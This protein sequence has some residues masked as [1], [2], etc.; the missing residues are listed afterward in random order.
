[1]RTALLIFGEVRGFPDLW[2]HIYDRIAAPNSADVFMHNYYYDE[3]FLDTHDSD[4]KNTIA[5]YYKNKGLNLFPNPELAKIFNPKAQILETRPNFAKEQ[6]ETVDKIIARL[7]HNKYLKN[8]RKFI[9]NDYS[10]IMGQHYS[11]ASTIKLKCAHEMENDFTYDAVI[12]TRLDINILDFFKVHRPPSSCL[13]KILFPNVSIFEQ[14]IMGRSSDINALGT[15]FDEAPLLYLKYCDRNR[16]FMSN[17]AFTYV[18]LRNSNIRVENFDYPLDYSD[19][20]NGLI[21][22]NKSFVFESDETETKT[23]SFNHNVVTTTKK[24]WTMF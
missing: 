13:A 22:F 7:E 10:A 15:M 8:G 16:Y 18:H 24:R 5:N 1:M 14:I 17:E 2:R 9:E 11:R 19:G 4:I 3:N 20:R 23:I 21:R 12:I 6:E